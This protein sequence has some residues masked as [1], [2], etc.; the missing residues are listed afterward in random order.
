LPKKERVGGM[1]MYSGWLRAVFAPSGPGEVKAFTLQAMVDGGWS[2]VCNVRDIP[3]YRREYPLS[4]YSCEVF[5]KPVECDRLRLIVLESHD[6]G[7][8]FTNLG[9]EPLPASQR[10]CNIREIELLRT[11]DR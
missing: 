8:R 7:W 3:P 6:A 2:D 5:F 4:A 9:G 10:W 1:R 11:K